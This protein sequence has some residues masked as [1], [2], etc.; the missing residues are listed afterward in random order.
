M[1]IQLVEDDAVYT[2]F[3]QLMF[4]NAMN[5]SI[6]ASASVDQF[7]AD[8]GDK[9]IDLLL[10]D[11]RRPDSVSIQD[12]VKELKALCSA[13][14]VF[15]TNGD[16]A[17][18]RDQAFEA[19]A[20]AVIDK[21]DL[22]EGLIR[23]IALN[24]KARG[25]SGGYSHKG[26]DRRKGDRRSADRQAGKSIESVSLERNFAALRAPLAYLESGLSTLGEVMR[27]T[28]KAGSSQF[29]DH[30]RETI[31]AI[32]QYTQDDLTAQ[33]GSSLHA[34]IQQ[35][36]L[37]IQRLA[38]T[39]DI[40]LRVDWEEAGFRHIGSDALV[41]LGVQHLLEGVL[42]CCVAKDGVW[43]QGEKADETGASVIRV[44]M[45]RRVLPSSD[46]LFPDA[47]PSL[48]VGLDAL[49]SMQ[50]GALLLMLS[51]KQVRLSTEERQQ[52]LSVYL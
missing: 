40:N 49:S 37:R 20:E 8:I 12:D 17:R 43:M 1:I 41:Q 18:L 13:P 6:N 39:R 7:K 26:K 28:G 38:Q 46:I 19:G 15:M 30:M 47:K 33:T 5:V 4:E 45:S 11:V 52:L 3:V 25:K 14:I 51:P 35:S 29:V 24:A 42:R 44:H 36:L 23:Q 50:L 21:A 2:E 22:S 9:H 34:L 10:V 48:G 27:E 16:T 31:Q 32:S